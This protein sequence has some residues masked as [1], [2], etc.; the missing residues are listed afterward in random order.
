MAGK[1]VAKK[2]SAG[3]NSRNKGFIERNWTLLLGVFAMG[4]LLFGIVSADGS[5]Q[6]KSLFLVGAVLLGLIAV[7][8]RREMFIALQ[9]VIVLGT[10]IGFFP[11][12]PDAGRY[13]LMIL[14]GLVALAFLL[15][16]GYFKTDRWGILGALGLFVL[17]LGFA[18]DP[19]VNPMWFN[20]FL[21]FGSMA[22]AAYSGIGFAGGVRIAVL[23]LLLNIAFAVKPLLSLA[24]M[25]GS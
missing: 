15:I 20:A 13:G 22:V 4:L 25:L 12:L 19:S 8:D 24:G 21:A 1:K 6:Q 9:A 23:W 10:V 14:G 2:K 11:F 16:R 5:L 3:K 18:T 17:A 7:A